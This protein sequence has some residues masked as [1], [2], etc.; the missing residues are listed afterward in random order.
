MY[1]LALTISYQ[2]RDEFGVLPSDNLMN[3]SHIL[4]VEGEDD[5]IALSKLLPNMS[6]ALKSAL[7]KHTLVIESLGGASKLNYNLNLWRSMFCNYFVFLDNDD[8]GRSAGEKAKNGGYITEAKIKYAICNGQTDSEFEDCISPDIY[9]QRIKDDFCVDIQSGNAFRGKNKWSDRVKNCFYSQGQ[10]WT[11]DIKKKVK[12]A[13]AECIP[14]N[15][16][17]ALNP[18]KRCSINALVTALESFI[19]NAV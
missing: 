3:A 6:P 9:S 10:L 7:H 4:V 5:K 2:I 1:D 19:S 12:L 17:D 15:P 13:V 11:D 8:A 18:H 14:D 16:D